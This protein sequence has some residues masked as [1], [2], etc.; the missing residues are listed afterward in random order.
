MVL[1]WMW[2]STEH[3]V[4]ANSFT[5]FVLEGI[6]RGAVWGQYLCT[7][8]RLECGAVLRCGCA[9]GH[10]CSGKRLGGDTWKG[11]GSPWT[12]KNWLD[13]SGGECES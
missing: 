8:C 6:L 11:Q 3:P 5:L 13:V 12:L 7:R 4:I 10:F 1:K 2:L 9:S